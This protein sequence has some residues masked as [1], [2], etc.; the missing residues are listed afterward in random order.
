MLSEMR[1]LPIKKVDREIAFS[2]STLTPEAVLEPPIQSS[3][4]VLMSL[5]MPDVESTDDRYCALFVAACSKD[6]A[7]VL[8]SQ[9]N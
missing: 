5:P 1:D 6:I 8:G 3:N 7:C 9:A 4:H 2:G